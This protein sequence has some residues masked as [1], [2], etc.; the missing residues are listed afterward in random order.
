MPTPRGRRYPGL[1]LATAAFIV[2]LIAG[3]A[4]I[5]SS[6]GGGPSIGGPFTLVNGDGKTVT[7]RDFH[8]RWML[9]YFGY[10]FCPD[11]CPTTLNQVAAALDALGPKGE[12]L[13]PV[14][15]SVDP[16]RDTPAVVKQ[17]AAA[18][19]PR[20]VGLTGSAEQIAAIAKEYRVYYAV[21]RTGNDP[22]DYSVDHSSVLYLVDP[23]GRFVAPIRADQS[24]TDMAATLARY[25]APTS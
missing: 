14:F 25:L 10:T 12:R 23:D 21:H 17:Y 8:G 7:D 15:I 1:M 3:A 6:Q 16:G 4:A 19:S 18:F 22:G 24:G 9:V 20:I 13:T 2:A 5:W 11:V